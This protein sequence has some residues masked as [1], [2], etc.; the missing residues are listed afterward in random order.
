MEATMTMTMTLTMSLASLKPKPIRPKSP[1]LPQTLNSSRIFKSL[2]LPNSSVGAGVGAPTL[3][4]HFDP[5][6]PIERAVTPPSSWYTDPSFY[7]QELHSVFYRGWQAV[8]FDL[9]GW[10][11]G[12][13][14]ALLKAT[15]ITGIQNFNKHDD[16]DY[17]ERSLNE[18][19]K[20]QMEDI[21]LCEGVQRGLESPAYNIGRYAPTVEN[22]MY[23]FHR[24]L[25]ESLRE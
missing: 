12:L 1:Y 15:R 5:T 2:S 16:R 19:E 4:D 7:A 13:D 22:A 21:V 18:S 17:I 11:Y 25:H 23:H 6:I 24:L 3:V 9:Q 20:V 14:G 8:E 10:T